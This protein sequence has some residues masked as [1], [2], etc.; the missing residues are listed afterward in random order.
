MILSEG[1]ILHNGRYTVIR[2]LGQGGFGC[3]YE[4]VEN[5]IF[6][7]RV[8][9]K[10]FFVKDYCNRDSDG[11]YVTVG[12]QSK[13][14]LVERLKKKFMD[15]A[16]VLHGIEHE[17]IVRVTDYF[18][19]N[20]TAYYVM[21]YIEGNSLKD[22]VDKRGPLSEQ[23]TVGY[24]RQLCETLKYIHSRSIL[25]LDIKP[26]NIMIDAKGDAILIDFG[27]AKQY[28]EIDGENTSTL[29]GMTPGYAPPEQMDHEVR[30]FTPSTDIYALGATFYKLLTGDTPPNAIKRIVNKRLT[31]PSHVSERVMNTI[32]QSMNLDKDDRPQS[33]EEFLAIL[34]SK[35]SPKEDTYVEVKVEPVPEP[36][37]VP[38]PT[39]TPVPDPNPRG[40][41]IILLILSVI[42]GFGG[43]Y[44][45]EV[46][47]NKKAGTAEYNRTH[48]SING[49]DWVDL[50]LSVKW[51]TSNVGAESPEDYGNYYAWGE[52]STKSEY[53][54]DNSKTYGKQMNDIGGRSQ[55]DA[56]RANWGG[57]WR[58]P[59]KAEME[60]LENRCTWKW[61]TQNGV[62][63]YKVTGPNGNSI[64]LPAAGYRSG[65]SLYTAGEYGRYWS[66]TPDESD[67]DIACI[68]HFY[69]IDQDVAWDNRYRG[70]SVRPVS[71]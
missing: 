47:E 7:E 16:L 65:S 15:E 27:T 6:K 13:K 9:I 60:E 5:N 11:M 3:T 50:G 61:T 42:L 14:T 37:P 58:L 41:W 23:E 2:F 49:H 25:H 66:S 19:E 1:M 4:A 26:G 71:E 12:T 33:V 55:Y 21:K 43:Y 64:F 54:K 28:D 8:A 24:I 35:T 18:E 38:V 57:T 48:G 68:L 56:A 29:M 44:A 39:P 32:E 67:S 34:D 70:L 51:A 69:S 10:E 52:T 22:I 45:Y 53:T 46:I 36:A 59:T 17:G 31:F 62:K 63:G 20:G 30:E 40:R